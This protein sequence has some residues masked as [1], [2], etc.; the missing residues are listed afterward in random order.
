MS[1]SV[2]KKSFFAIHHSRQCRPSVRYRRGLGGRPPTRSPDA[3]C[4]RQSLSPHIC[5]VNGV[6]LL[7]AA[8]PDIV[9]QRSA[10]GLGRVHL[11]DARAAF[12]LDIDKIFGR[13]TVSLLRALRQR[14]SCPKADFVFQHLLI[15]DSGGGARTG[16]TLGKAR[17]ARTN[18][19]PE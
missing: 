9:E 18:S 4:L 16:S 5:A 13:L 7:I 17:S 8:R 11:V 1:G 3:G 14:R 12:V 6:G 19:K 15:L 10:G 2:S